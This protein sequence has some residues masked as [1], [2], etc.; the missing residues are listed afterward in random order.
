LTG[1]EPGN[2]GEKQLEPGHGRETADVTRKRVN[3]K[4]EE[5]GRLFYSITAIFLS[6]SLI[7]AEELQDFRRTIGQAEI[8]L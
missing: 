5:T 3:E 8:V 7:M 1:I 6:S 2:L 4:K